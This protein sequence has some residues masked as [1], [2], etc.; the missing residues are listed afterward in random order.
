MTKYIKVIYIV[1]FIIVAVVGYSWYRSC[2]ESPKEA[3]WRGQ[4]EVLKANV[5][6]ERVASL[7]VIESLEGNISDKDK[8]IQRF[9]E[10]VK[11]IESKVTE[12]SRKIGELEDAYSD[13]QNDTER[14]DNLIQQVAQWKEKFLLSETIIAS[15][16]KII[17]SLTEKYES[18]LKI[19]NEYK[20]LYINECEMSRVLTMR[21]DIC[22][23]KSKGLKFSGTIKNGIVLTLAGVIV[24]GLVSK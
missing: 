20:S 19:T 23:K 7:K 6:E 18:Q 21:L 9:K 10:E 12:K 16:D 8:A 14:V 24:Y 17:F 22:T 2:G 1:L 4:Y 5:E 13:L 11:V 3:Y 15:K